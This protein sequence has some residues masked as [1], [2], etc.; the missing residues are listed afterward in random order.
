MEVL[1]SKFIGQLRLVLPWRS[2]DIFYIRTVSRVKHIE[3]VTA[4]R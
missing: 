1:G 4:E 2:E 3:Q